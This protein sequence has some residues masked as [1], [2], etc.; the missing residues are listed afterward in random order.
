[1][2]IQ[3]P[4]LSEIT[5]LQFEINSIRNALDDPDPIW[6]LLEAGVNPPYT[7]DN[8][9]DALRQLTNDLKVKTDTLKKLRR[10]YENLGKVLDEANKYDLE[11]QNRKPRISGGVRVG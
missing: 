6:T 1:M 9:D 5:R 3:I 4:R 8:Y 11:R 2:L 10:V 7:Q